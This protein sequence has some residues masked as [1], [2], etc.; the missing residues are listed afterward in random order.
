[1][2]FTLHDC[3]MSEYRGMNMPA[4]HGISIEL[5]NAK[6]AEWENEAI[7][8]ARSIIQSH[9][10]RAPLGDD[11]NELCCLG[12]AEECQEWLAKYRSKKK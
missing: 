3:D 7:E 9:S 11:E 10:L 6:L 8:E 12:D 5:A 1:M 4:K 2:K